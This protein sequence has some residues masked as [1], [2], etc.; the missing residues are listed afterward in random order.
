MTIKIPSSLYGRNGKED[1]EKIMNEKEEDKENIENKV[2]NPIV[3]S[4]EEKG[5]YIYVPSINLYVAK[6]R[7]LN[8]QDWFECH[9]EL[10]ANN[11]RMLI[12]PEFIEFLK[13]SKTNF[14]DVYNEMTEVRDPSRREWI[15]ADFKVKGKDLYVNY[16]HIVD[17]N[18]NLI[19]QNSEILDKNTLMKD[20][21]PGIS[22]EDYLNN[23]HTSQGFPNKNVKSGDLYYWYP[24]S[25]NN[26]VA[27]FVADSDG[28]VLDCGRDPSNGNSSLGVM[29]VLK[30]LA[31]GIA[32]GIK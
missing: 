18:G 11:K 4:N 1:Y 6:E 2:N 31:S 24:K 14:P 19:P 26:S 28:A 3:L 15:D 21:I 16:N 17:K 7:T 27:R 13:Y 12:M 29:A 8:G 5:N 25:D 20:K 30:D 22:L 10:Q 23:N 9:K 32:G